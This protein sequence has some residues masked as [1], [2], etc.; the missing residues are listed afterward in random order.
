MGFSEEVVEAVWKKGKV[1]DGYDSDVWRHDDFGK[2]MKYVEYG[3]RESKYGWE[4][5]HIIPIE[6]GGTD[7]LKNL[8]QLHYKSNLARNKK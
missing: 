3:D 4:K 2:V 6:N 5:D 7:D 8:R 1:I